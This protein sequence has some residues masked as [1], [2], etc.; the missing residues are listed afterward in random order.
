M[1]RFIRDLLAGRMFGHPIHAMLVHFPA[2]LYPVTLVLDVLARVQRDGS[3]AA[4][5]FYTATAAVAGAAGAALF[6]A[7]DYLKLDSANPAWLK[8]SLHAGLN[9]VWASLFAVIFGL[10]LPHYPAVPPPSNALIILA[11]VGT[12]GM[13]FSNFLGGELVFRYGIGTRPE[14]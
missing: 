10:Q 9:I 4:A 5:G 2:A 1:I 14:K 13:L 11:G 8:A 7:I 12:V 3:F 6:G